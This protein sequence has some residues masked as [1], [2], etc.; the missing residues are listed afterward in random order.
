M[1][2]KQFSTYCAYR[3]YKSVGVIRCRVLDHKSA[4]R[5]LDVNL[6]LFFDSVHLR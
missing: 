4:R 1:L 6:S 3:Y 5:V 2:G